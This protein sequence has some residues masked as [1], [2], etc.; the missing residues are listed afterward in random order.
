ML[1]PPLRG[2]VPFI[3]ISG[4]SYNKDPKMKSIDRC[5]QGFY[6]MTECLK[7]EIQNPKSKIFY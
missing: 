6:K 1:Q 7:S 4:N 2:P 3:R 5:R